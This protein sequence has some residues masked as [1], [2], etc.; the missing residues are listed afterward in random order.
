MSPVTN[1]KRIENIYFAHPF[2]SSERG[3]NEVIHRFIRRE[4]PK[5]MSLENV[6]P[7]AYQIYVKKINFYP[8]K[9]LHG[10]CAYDLFTKEISKI[11]T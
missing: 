6:D 2:C 11:V 1:E 7:Y 3:S 4:F 5:G 8:R 9:L 10:K